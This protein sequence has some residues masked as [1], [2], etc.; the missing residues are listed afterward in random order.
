[1]AALPLV[2]VLTLAAV[3]GARREGSIGL[4][5]LRTVLLFSGMLLAAGLIAFAVA[6]PAVALYPVDADTASAFVRPTR[7]RC[8]RRSPASRATPSATGSSP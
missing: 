8:H 2:V 5:S 3:A 6:A 7:R 4:L 1:M